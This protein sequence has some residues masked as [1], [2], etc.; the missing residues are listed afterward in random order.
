MIGCPLIGSSRNG[1]LLLGSSQEFLHEWK[2]LTYWMPFADE[3]GCCTP[4]RKFF[5]WI[6]SDLESLPQLGLHSNRIVQKISKNWSPTGSQLRS[7]WIRSWAKH[8]I[9]ESATFCFGKLILNQM[10]PALLVGI[11]KAGRCGQ[12]SKQTNVYFWGKND[13]VWLF[14]KTCLFLNAKSEAQPSL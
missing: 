13:R 1:S 11:L 10:W 14:K 6:H 5:Q 2:P 4:N 12:T 7:H 9:R 3:V 8:Q